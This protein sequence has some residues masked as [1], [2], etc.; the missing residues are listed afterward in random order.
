MM[1]S[2]SG[3]PG[4]ANVAGGLNAGLNQKQQQADTYNQQLL[5]MTKPRYE[6]GEDKD[7]RIL[8]KTYPAAYEYDPVTSTVREIPGAAAQKP[9]IEV[10]YDPTEKEGNE[11]RGT[12]TDSRGW[13]RYKDDN[14]LVEPNAYEEGYELSAEGR[15]SATRILREEYKSDIKPIED[16]INQID[17]GV[18]TAA[19][20]YLDPESTAA[21]KAEADRALV[22]LVEKLWDPTSAVLGG[23]F[24][25]AQAAQSVIDQAVRTLDLSSGETL[26]NDK[27]R[28]LLDILRLV[29]EEKV[30]VYNERAGDLSSRA[31]SVVEPYRASQAAGVIDAALPRSW[32]QDG[33]GNPADGYVPRAL[34]PKWQELMSSQW[35]T[36]R[37]PIPDDLPPPSDDLNEQAQRIIRGR[38]SSLGGRP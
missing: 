2:Q 8:R 30:G 3:Q 22:K 15:L 5:Q 24:E 32:R 37:A 17:L 10:L 29:G 7:G 35:W 23:E 26:G 4:F 12:F 38:S 21:Q 20:A 14:S 36:E 34:D 1:L 27:R 18:T 6:E 19:K 31:S 33:Q 16:E 28:A 25:T 13:L 9:K 11:D